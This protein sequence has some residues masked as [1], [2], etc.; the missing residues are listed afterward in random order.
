MLKLKRFILTILILLGI[1]P[2][3][4]E[5][6][7]KGEF[8]QVQ[9]T[10]EAEKEERLLSDD[11]A[12][13]TLLFYCIGSD[14]ET[15]AGL[16]SLDL[17]EIA[18]SD[19]GDQVKVVAEVGGSQNW[20]ASALTGQT[21][22]R[23]ILQDGMI[24]DREDVGTISMVNP[25]TLTDFISWGTRT[26]PADRYGIILWDHGGGTV[27]GFGKDEMFPDESMRVSE[28]QEAFADAGVKFDFIAF[29][30]CLMSTVEIAY[31]LAPYGDYMIAS[32]ETAPG[33]GLSYTG[34]LSALG[35]HPAMDTE[36]IGKRIIS[37]YMDGEAAIAAPR[38]MSMLEL[39]KVPALYEALCAYFSGIRYRLPANYQ[40]F[41]YARSLA[42]D[43]GQGGFDQIDLEHF[44]QLAE[45]WAGREATDLVEDALK[46]VVVYT[47]SNVTNSNGIAIYYP[48]RYPAIYSYMLE[49]LELLGMED[50]EYQGYFSD[51]ATLTNMGQ[52]IQQGKA[53]LVESAVGYLFGLG[54][55]SGYQDYQGETWYND[56]LAEQEQEV[57]VQLDGE[58]IAAVDES[59]TYLEFTDEEWDIISDITLEVFLMD[60]GGYMDMG[61]DARYTYSGTSLIVDYDGCWVALDGQKVTYYHDQ[62][63]NFQDGTAYQFGRVP[64]L[65][66]GDNYIEIVLYW[67]EEY[68]SGAV[69]GYYLGEDEEE[70]LYTQPQLLDFRRDDVV[71]FC[72][73]LYDWDDEEKDEVVIS[74]PITV[75]DGLTISYEE[76]GD[77]AI[78]YRYIITDVYQNQYATDLI[79]Y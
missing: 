38:T 18:S 72:Y 36:E 79:L 48:Y 55:G 47:R 75:G 9:E 61:Q 74:E 69:L 41:L 78:C 31:A 57:L 34:W 39:E 21:V 71:E 6:N 44:I 50:K 22:Q 4:M 46:D 2:A 20:Q 1:A 53:G 12:T 73:L 77:T 58:A 11:T 52:R 30:A 24:K 14:L 45:D 35:E 29:D 62:L 19:L 28:L 10:Q 5:I 65:L 32:E 33:D 59:G 49:E 3:D 40:G 43:Y 76:F 37:E 42:K 66:N 63:G 16:A 23:F 13:F 64:A 54:G 60:D 8:V 7:S 70:A 25:R 68:P 51:F 27:S 26:Y 67:D 17:L 56:Q 15:Q